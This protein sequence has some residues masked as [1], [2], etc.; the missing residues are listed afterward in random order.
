MPALSATGLD[1]RITHWSKLAN[2]RVV[3]ILALSAA[4]LPCLAQTPAGTQIDGIV[5]DTITGAPVRRAVIQL[6]ISG[7]GPANLPSIEN[8]DYAAVTGPDGTFHF[9]QIPPGAYSLSYSRSGYLMPRAASGYSPRTVRA[10]AGQAVKGLRY[11]LIPQAIVSG[12]VLD[13]EGDP[14]EGVQ[15]SL[16]AFRYSGGVRHLD[17][18]SEAGTTNDRGEYRIAHVPAGKYLLQASLDRLP[19]GSALLTGARTPVSYT[20]LTLPTILRV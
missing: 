3:R 18:L 19:P 5:V 14:V 15:V 16:L 4:L 8:A 2:S 13:D 12:R 20:H 6:R 11:G 7:G 17:R 10:A 1:S 9:E